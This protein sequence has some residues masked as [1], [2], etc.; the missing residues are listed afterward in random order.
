VVSKVEEGN[1]LR[2][3][4]SKD[5]RGE[6]K[7][8]PIASGSSCCAARKREGEDQERNN[9]SHE[10]AA[11]LAM[12]RREKKKGAISEREKAEKRGRHLSLISFCRPSKPRRERGGRSWAWLK[13]L[14]KGEKGKGVRKPQFRFWGRDQISRDP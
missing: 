1:S 9:A 14:T 10:R 8:E 13:N 2:G 4:R 6:K 12:E 7:E 11:A 5:E 3:R